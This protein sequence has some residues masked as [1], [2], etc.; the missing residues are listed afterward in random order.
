MQSTAERM[1]LVKEKKPRVQETFR[2][3]VRRIQRKIGKY[4]TIAGAQ[5]LERREFKGINGASW[6]KAHEGGT[7][8][9]R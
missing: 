5:S 9:V 6:R 2:A 3:G 8:K 1:S 7:S 4:D